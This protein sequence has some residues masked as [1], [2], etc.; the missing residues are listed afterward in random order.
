M[1][2]SER[3]IIFAPFARGEHGAGGGFGLGLAI[4]RRIVEAHRGRVEVSDN[5]GGGAC[6]TIVMPA[7]R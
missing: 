5:P 6:F 2:E 1:P 3:T 7:A 4:T